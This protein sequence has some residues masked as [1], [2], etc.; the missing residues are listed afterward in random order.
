MEEFYAVPFE[1]R[2]SASA[3]MLNKY[4]DKIPSIICLHTADTNDICKKKHLISRELTVRLLLKS[5]KERT[6]TDEN[7]AIYL[8]AETTTGAREKKQTLLSASQTIGEVYESCRSA[9]GC[10]YIYYNKE[11]TFG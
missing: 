6:K 10:L 7:I 4:P 9:D 2:R 11:Q 1:Q 8:I 3:K 5:I